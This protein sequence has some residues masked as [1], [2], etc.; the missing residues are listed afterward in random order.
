MVPSLEPPSE[1]TITALLSGKYLA[2]PACTARTTWPIV[3]AL[4][5][6]GNT[7]ND[8]GTLYLLNLVVNLRSECNAAHDPGSPPRLGLLY[9][10]LLLHRARSFL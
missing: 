8:V 7:D 10:V 3:R 4:L 6:V 9:H 1:F 2:S 5:K